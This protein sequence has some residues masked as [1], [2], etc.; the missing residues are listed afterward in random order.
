MVVVIL[1]R[2]KGERRG[3][4]G[5]SIGIKGLEVGIT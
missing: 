4:T 2:R 1:R 3:K 5:L